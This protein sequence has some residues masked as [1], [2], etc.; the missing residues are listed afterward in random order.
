MLHGRITG[1]CGWPIIFQVNLRLPML[2]HFPCESFAFNTRYMSL[3]GQKL[4][5]FRNVSSFHDADNKTVKVWKFYQGCGHVIYEG[6]FYY[7]IGGTNTLV[8]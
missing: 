8:K 2:S 3:P 6:A 1:D 5:E 4:L 7:Q